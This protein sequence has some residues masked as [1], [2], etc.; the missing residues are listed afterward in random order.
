MGVKQMKKVALFLLVFSS[1]AIFN[2]QVALASG[3]K[4][5]GEKAEGDAYL[6]CVS[7]DGT[8]PFTG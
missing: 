8:C 4:V 5:R 3:D 1:A 6:N 2:T 7:N